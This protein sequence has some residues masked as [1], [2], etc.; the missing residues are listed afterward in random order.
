[1]HG[2]ASGVLAVVGMDVIIRRTVD[3]DA[4]SD[5]ATAFEHLAA[6]KVEAHRNHLD[7]SIEVIL[8]DLSRSG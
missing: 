7:P 3:P 5:E 1:M 4:G 2:L 8:R 6:V